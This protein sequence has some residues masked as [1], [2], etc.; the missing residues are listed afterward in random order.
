MACAASPGKMLAVRRVEQVQKSCFGL[1]RENQG[2]QIA[3]SSPHS[4][5]QRGPAI[6]G[7]NDPNEQRDQIDPAA[8]R[9]AAFAMPVPIERPWIANPTYP[10]RR[11][12][13]F[14][15]VPQRAQLGPP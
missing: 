8:R 4:V 14:G 12:L 13:A 3:R 10:C 6:A 1:A 9:E 5:S 7:P 2:A 15:P 11:V